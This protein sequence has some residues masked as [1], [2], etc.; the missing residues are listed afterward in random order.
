MNAI[1]FKN[2]GGEILLNFSTSIQG[3]IVKNMYKSFGE[4]IICYKLVGGYITKLD[5]QLN[6]AIK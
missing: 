2:I 4:F 3:Y 1:I 5:F 6:Y